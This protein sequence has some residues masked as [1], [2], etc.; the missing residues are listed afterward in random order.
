MN[1]GIKKIIKEKKFIDGKIIM[2]EIFGINLFAVLVFKNDKLVDSICN[3]CF[4]K[5]SIKEIMRLT[6]KIY[7]EKLKEWFYD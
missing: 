3:F 5:S 6:R 2:C 1:Y 4:K 7:K